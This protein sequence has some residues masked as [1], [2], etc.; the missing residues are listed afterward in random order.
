MR[1]L[2]GPAMHPVFCLTRIAAR[3]KPIYPQS[4]AKLFS[5]CKLDNEVPKN[6]IR[7]R[8]AEGAL[9]LCRGVPL[10]PRGVN[11]PR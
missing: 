5:Q 11:A 9:L 8:D 6:K 3:G 1:G 2:F 7:T 4:I 10:A